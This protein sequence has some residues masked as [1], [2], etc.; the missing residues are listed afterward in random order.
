[1][2]W[3]KLLMKGMKDCSDEKNTVYPVYELKKILFSAQVVFFKA[4]S[5]LSVSV[6]MYLET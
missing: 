4:R 5:G 2:N 6:T 1:M 3:H